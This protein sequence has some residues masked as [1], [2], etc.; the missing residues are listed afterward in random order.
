MKRQDTNILKDVLQDFI[1]EGATVAKNTRNKYMK[2]RTLFVQLNSS[3]VRNQLFMMRQDIV[4]ELNKRMEKSLV[5]ELV[6]N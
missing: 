2:G 6:L 4:N 1:K 5:D 3:V